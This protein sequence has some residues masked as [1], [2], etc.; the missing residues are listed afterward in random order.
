MNRQYLQLI[1]GTPEWHAFRSGRFTASETPAMLGVSPHQ[2]REQLLKEKSRGFSEE[3]SGFVE[4]IYS[5]GHN[6]EKIALPWAEEIIGKDLFMPT[7]SVEVEGLKMSSS[8]DGLTFDEETVWEHKTL[9][10]KLAK[11]IP[12]KKIDLLYASQMESELLVSGAEVC[13][14]MASNGD[15]E[16]MVHCWYESD[17]ELR[18]KIIAGWHQFAKDLENYKPEPVAVEVVGTALMSLPSLAISLTGSVN[19]SNLAEYKKSAMTMIESINTDLQ[20]DQDFADAEQVVKLCAESEKALNAAKEAALSQTADIDELFKT[21]A[22]LRESMRSKRLS[23]EKLVKSQKEAIKTKVVLDGKN[24]IFR[25]VADLNEEL[26]VVTI[27]LPA[28]DFASAIK[29]KRNLESIK[30]AINQVVADAKIEADRLATLVRANLKTLT[31]AGTEHLGLFPDLQQ[32]CSKPNDDFSLLVTSRISS[33]K[34]EVERQAKIESDKLI[35]QKQTEATP[36]ETVPVVTRTGYRIAPQPEPSPPTTSEK[37]AVSRAL[38]LITEGYSDL[39]N[40]LDQYGKLKEFS[41]ICEEIRFT[42]KRRKA[43]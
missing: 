3:V 40:F 2:T 19:S 24:I 14:F 8:Y 22:H 30:S 28:A 41:S 17:P 36:A 27:P 37:P 16:S 29:G 10:K 9:N 4:K 25:H 21:I 12:E 39:Q 35:E 15:R 33:H 6:Y 38:E 18:E 31:D 13:L 32:I 26:E 1:Q 11:D 5:D 23:L 42:L 20:T 7:I 34:A 43:A